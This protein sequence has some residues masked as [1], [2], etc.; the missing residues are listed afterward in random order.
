MCFLKC[1]FRHY[2]LVTIFYYNP[3][4]RIHFFRLITS[5]SITCC[6]SINNCSGINLIKQYIH[7]CCGTPLFY[8]IISW[9]IPLFTMLF[10]ILYTGINVVSIQ[11][12]GNL[13]I[14]F[15]IDSHL[16]YKSDHLCRF[17]INNELLFIT[18]RP[19]ITI[20]SLRSY[21]LTSLC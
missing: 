11:I 14:F 20:W 8:F 6:L 4:I 15:P 2:R 21:K 18:F 10:F 12:S 5:L 7:N 9:V 3:I 17:F 16:K 19:L 13:L 1:L